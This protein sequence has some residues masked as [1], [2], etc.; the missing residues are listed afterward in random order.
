MSSITGSLSSRFRI[1]TYSAFG[2]SY[3]TGDQNFPALTTIYTPTPTCLNRWI[4]PYPSSTSIVVYSTS[5]SGRGDGDSEWIT[6]QPL[7]YASLYSP[8]A[9]PNQQTI[10][11]LREYTLSFEGNTARGWQAYCCPRYVIH[12]CSMSMAYL[13]L[14]QT[15]CKLRY[16]L[17]QRLP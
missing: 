16:K 17:Q 14:L 6:C 7:G 10:E 8:G 13:P 11:Y 12:H 5:P 15:C 3:D 1:S 2:S 4:L 9:C